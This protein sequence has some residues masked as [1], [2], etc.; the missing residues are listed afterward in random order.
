MNILPRIKFFL[1]FLFSFFAIQLF[2]EEQNIPTADFLHLQ[3][4][5]QKLEIELQL[6]RDEHEIMKLQRIYGYYVDKGLSDQVADLFTNDATLEIAG[7][8][9]YVGI[10]SIRA[11]MNTLPQLERGLL[12]DHMQLQPVIHVSRD[13]QSAKGRIRAFIQNGNYGKNAIW[14]G[15][16]YE[17]EY[18]KEEGVW[19]ISKLHFFTTYYANYADGWSK[20][21]IP[22][23]G[24]LP[25]LPPD[26]PPSVLYESYP[27]VY[28]PPFHYRNPVTGK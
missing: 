2:A 14:G 18:I 13:G 7:R 6:L 15:G 5:I 10:D 17:N 24:E 19:K 21:A 1:L 3:E 8:G 9:V 26:R 27:G 22:L 11:Y 12:F 25:G 28:I 4:R 20:N 23:F 16:V